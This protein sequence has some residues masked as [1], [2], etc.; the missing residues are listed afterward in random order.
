MMGF[1]NLIGNEHAK[2]LLSKIIKQN[3]IAHSYLFLGPSGVGKTLFAKE[4][5]KMILCLQEEKPCKYCKSCIQFEENNQPDFTIISPED[6]IIKIE[7]IRQMQSKLLEKPIISSKKVYLIKDAD[8]MTREAANCLL[9]TLEEPPSFITIILIASNESLL[10]NTIRSRCMK[11]LFRKIEEQT[12]KQYLQQS[13]IAE[14]L[15]DELLKA[16]NGSIEKAIHI[17]K[18]KET[19]E[20]VQNIF[21]NI[22]QYT[23]LDV[24]GKLDCLYKN[25]D[26]IYDILD[27]IMVIFA[28]KAVYQE[29]YITYIETIEEVKKNLKSNSN[30]DMSIDRILYKIWEE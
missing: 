3:T 13:H 8:T 7:A 29:K 20:E 22:E 23:L 21:S 12:L 4:F 11:V 18:Q 27:Y 17:Q 14:G 30:Y 6:G 9:K 28:R 26:I 10:L 15:T 2:D 5:A 24:I 25:K 1:E 16:C 19:Y